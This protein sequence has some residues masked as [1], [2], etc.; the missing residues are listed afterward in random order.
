MFLL[1]SQIK[2]S[3]P[4]E[5]SFLITYISSDVLYHQTSLPSLAYS[6]L[7]L[8]IDFFVKH[9]TSASLTRSVAPLPST[10]PGTWYSP[11]GD[12]LNEP[13]HSAS[14]LPQGDWLRAGF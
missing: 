12:V 3:P 8:C 10:V 2:G 7:G 9:K 13:L 6:T 11:S 1:K 14:C 5:R 4:L